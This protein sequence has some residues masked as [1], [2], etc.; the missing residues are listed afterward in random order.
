MVANCTK[1]GVAIIVDAV[2][3]HMANYGPGR[4]R[5]GSQVNSKCDYPGLYSC[6]D[7]NH[8]DPCPDGALRVMPCETTACTYLASTRHATM[9][10]GWVM[11]IA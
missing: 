1:H 2:I 5:N 6:G 8:M 10:D 11:R 3:N 9:V 7:F 4:G